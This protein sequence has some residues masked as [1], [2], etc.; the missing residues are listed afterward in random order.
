MKTP[1]QTEE[2]TVQTAPPEQPAAESTA[3]QAAPDEKKAVQH[4]VLP[5]EKT[6]EAPPADKPEP[7]P[8]SIDPRDREFLTALS[9]MLDNRNNTRARPEE[10]VRSRFAQ[11][12]VNKG[13]GVI[14]LALI[15]VM[16]GA[17]LIWCLFSHAPD[18]LLPLKL[19]PAAAV[20][21]GLEIIAHYFAS[22]KH[23]NVHVP[24]ICISALLIVGC[25]FMAV[26]LNEEYSVTKTEYNNRSVAAQIYDSSY[27]ELRY[28]ADIDSLEITVDLNPDG[29][30][31]EKGI[32]ALSTDDTVTVNIVLG[33][34]YGSAREFAGECKQLIDG[35]RILGIPITEYHFKNEGKFH[36]FRLDVVGKFAQDKT[37]AELADEVS[38]VYIEDYDYIDDLEDF[39]DPQTE[40]SAD[41]EE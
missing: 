39:V 4:G 37:E 19:A 1:T 31:R 21:I 2:T 7:P 15:L 17:V 41:S 14:S 3:A 22:G 25:C 18:Y 33:G 10:P 29:T 11:V 35:Y 34:T 12:M 23:L 9:V 28:V 36:S 16:M 40:E 32:E 8:D 5:K 13:V 20:I 27:K 30:G 38:H 6:P 24:S 26:K